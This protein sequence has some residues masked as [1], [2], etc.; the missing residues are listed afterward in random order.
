MRR[1][2]RILIAAAVL[3]FAAP[4]MA[5]DMAGE[6]A[7]RIAPDDRLLT[8]VYIDGRGPFTFVIDSASS[9]TVIFE[10]VRQ[11][12]GLDYSGPE[13]I[14]IYGI[15]D[16]TM[17]R[18]AN[19][20]TV[21]VAG[22]AVKGVTIGI[23]P[24]AAQRGDPDGILGIDILARYLVV[25]DR[26][27]MQLR[28]VERTSAQAQ[29]YADWTPLPLTKR[30]L[31][32][33]PVTFWYLTTRYNEHPVSSLFDLGAGLTL[34]NWDAAA[35]LGLYE[36]KY[37]KYGPPPEDVRDVLG[38]AAPAVVIPSAD[39]SLGGFAWHKKE[40]LVS[41]APVF[42]FLEMA[43]RPGAIVGPGLLKDT[44]LAIDFQGQTLYVGPSL[45]AGRSGHFSIQIQQEDYGAR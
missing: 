36:R 30:P 12:L 40:L 42:D 45:D 21:S 22:L 38:K 8:D 33:L 15:N 39:V 4:V 34:L 24:D 5:S 17:A 43:D 6:Q 20:Q 41:S 23:L 44:S 10:H 35:Q 28:L 18:A 32:N 14:K 9:R 31:K 11:A 7:Y 37:E 29:A 27:A 26:K 13:P 2:T 19:P 1:I 3:A 25:L 16:V